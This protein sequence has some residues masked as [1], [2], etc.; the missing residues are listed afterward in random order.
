MEK[1]GS[2]FK[3]FYNFNN[4]NV[5]KLVI[6]GTAFTIIIRIKLYKYGYI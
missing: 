5:H 6:Y 3:S 4:V 1:F 2:L